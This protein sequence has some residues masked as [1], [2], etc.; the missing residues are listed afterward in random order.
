MPVILTRTIT[1]KVFCDGMSTMEE[2]CSH[3]HSVR[4]TRACIGLT[5]EP[6]IETTRVR[7]YEE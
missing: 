1:N 3:D 5:Q 2:I 4:D 6:A 7:F